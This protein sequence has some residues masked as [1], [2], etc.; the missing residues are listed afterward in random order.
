[1][2]INLVKFRNWINGEPSEKTKKNM[3]TAEKI[4]ERVPSSLIDRIKRE[5][6]YSEERSRN[7]WN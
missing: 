3:E 2:K 6:D 7:K 1:M 5:A 4:M